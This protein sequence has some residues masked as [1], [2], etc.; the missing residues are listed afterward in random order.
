MATAY[1]LEAA[2]SDLGVFRKG[3]KYER[4]LI[5]LYEISNGTLMEDCEEQIQ[6]LKKL[7][8]VLDLNYFPATS[9]SS[10]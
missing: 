2:L 6:T 5:T 8:F 1:G 10:E 3:S 9:S 7:G 4:S